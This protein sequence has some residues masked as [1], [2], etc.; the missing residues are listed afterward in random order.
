M[1]AMSV[2]RCG[3]VELDFI[4]CSLSD[5]KVALSLWGIS[6]WDMCWWGGDGGSFRRESFETKKRTYLE[7]AKQYFKL[8]FVCFLFFFF[9]DAKCLFFNFFV[10]LQ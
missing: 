2:S 10:Y 3:G 8:T 1:E 7:A 9:K 4:L 5:F 6:Y